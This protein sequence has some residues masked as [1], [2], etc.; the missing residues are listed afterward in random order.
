MRHIEDIWTRNPQETR[1]VLD[2]ARAYLDDVIDNLRRLSRDLS[3]HLLEDLGLSAALRHLLREFCKYYDFQQCSVAIDEIDNLFPQ[4]AQINIYRIFQECLTNIGKYARASLV[5]VNIQKQDGEV[6]F[7]VE[8]NGVGFD[9]AQLAARNI[10]DKGLGL[11][12]M[13]ERVRMLG[14]S[15]DLWSQEGAGTRIAF[16]LPVKRN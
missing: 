12:A 3:P 8:D 9:V 6:A 1:A 5:K 14:G 16:S 7:S 4:E 15:L 11:A 2:H 10:Y 13:E